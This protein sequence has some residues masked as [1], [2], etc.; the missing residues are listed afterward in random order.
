LARISKIRRSLASDYVQP[1]FEKRVYCPPMDITTERVWT[2]FRE[3]RELIPLVLSLTNSVVQ[4]FTANALLALGASPIMSEALEEIIELVGIA[5]ALNLNIGTPTPRSAEAMAL[6]AQTAKARQIPIV[7][8]PVA[9]GVTKLRR[10]LADRL[11][12]IAPSAIIRGNQAEIAALAGIPA[13]ARGVDAAESSEKASLAVRQLAKR[14][15]T[16]AVA[17]GPIDYLSDGKMVI[18]VDNGHP[19]M[20]RI[21]GSGCVASALIAAFLAVNPNA[22]SAAMSAVIVMDIVGELAAEHSR[23]EGPSSF[24]IRFLDT[25][26]KLEP[27]HLEARMKVT[28]V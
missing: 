24:R 4:E 3:V 10:D 20:A 12:E 14:L 21:T 25:F 19:M 27:E 23:S 9:V 5:S 26:D 16:V 28:R 15:G 11:L 18:A 1:S 7:L 17:S 6:A 2:D 8:D 13:L 22:L